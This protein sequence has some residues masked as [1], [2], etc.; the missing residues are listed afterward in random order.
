MK[1]VLFLYV[2]TKA[3]YI[4]D[5]KAANEQV[6]SGERAFKLYDTYGFPLELTEEILEERG[7]ELNKEEF[8]VHMEDQRQRAIA[9]LVWRCSGKSS[10]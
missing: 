3:D 6:F 10:R 4:K 9:T 1:K 2:L 5:M 7:I 8:K